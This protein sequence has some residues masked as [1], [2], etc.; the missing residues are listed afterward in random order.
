MPLTL[1]RRRDAEGRGEIP[2]PSV[3]ERRCLRDTLHR[4]RCDLGLRVID[5]GQA[6]DLLDIEHGVALHVVNL[7]LRFLA[8]LV[9]L[10]ARDGVRVDDQ[11]AFLALADMGMK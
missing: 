10:V 2:R 1:Y 11:R 3:E 8:A 4:R 5:L 6:L 9:R 7:A